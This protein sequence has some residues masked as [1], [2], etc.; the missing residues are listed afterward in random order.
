MSKTFQTITTI[1]I[2]ILAFFT[3]LFT[4]MGIFEM[5]DGMRLYTVSEDSFIYAL[6]DGRYGDLVESY[7][8]NLVSDVKATNTMKEC[9]AIARYYEAAIDYKLAVQEKGTALQPTLKEKTE[10]AANE[11]GALSYAKKEINELLG[12]Y[13]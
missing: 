11:M 6:E 12:L 10:T 1:I 8:R 3:I 5:A 2:A 9:Y 13:F 4:V 7:H